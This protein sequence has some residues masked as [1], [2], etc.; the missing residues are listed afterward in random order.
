MNRFKEARKNKGLGQKEVAIQLGVAQPTVSDWENG[1]KTPT[2][3]N[4]KALSKLYE[5]SLDY[6]VGETEQV[7]E[8][9]LCNPKSPGKEPELDINSIEYALYGEA[10]ELDEEEKK[11]LLALVKVMR[12]KRQQFNK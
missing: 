5:V 11:Q 4:I 1:H 8:S 3:D 7:A 9:D 12:K 10:K 2:L 6:L